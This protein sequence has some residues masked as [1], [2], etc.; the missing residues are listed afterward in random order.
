MSEDELGKQDIKR[1]YEAIST[2]RQDDEEFD[3]AVLI[4]FMSIGE[5][6]TAEGKKYL[7]LIDG[8]GSG[9]RLH[10]WQ[11]QGYC[12]NLLH[13]PLWGPDRKED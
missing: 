5:W 7:T 9:E 10:R 4:G 6:I 8:N 11:V 2:S 1:V 12:F 13:D 3:G